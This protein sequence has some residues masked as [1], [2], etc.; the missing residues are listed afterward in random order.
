MSYDK[1][2]QGK[3]EI[4]PKLNPPVYRWQEDMPENS[5]PQL[6][7]PQLIWLNTK[8]NI[9]MEIPRYTCVMWRGMILGGWLTFLLAFFILVMSIIIIKDTI[10]T[11]GF[12]AGSVGGITFFLFMNFFILSVFFCFLRFILLNPETNLSA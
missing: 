3:S 7:P 10:Y 12:I 5:E 1:F 8:N 11:W 6:V 4:Q 2:L 9:W